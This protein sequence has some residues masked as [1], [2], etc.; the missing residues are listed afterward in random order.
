MAQGLALT[1][2]ISTAARTST[3]ASGRSSS[4]SGACRRCCSHDIFL[5]LTPDEMDVLVSGEP[6]WDWE[7]FQARVRYGEY[8]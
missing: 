1:F 2:A 6:S 4:S 3:C 7:Q 8:R 5:R